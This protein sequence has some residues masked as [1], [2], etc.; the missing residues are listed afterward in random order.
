MAT[1]CGDAWAD[2]T[3][4]ELARSEASGIP[5]L[6]HSTAMPYS[7]R[8]TRRSTDKR[9]LYEFVDRS[10]KQPIEDEDD[11]SQYFEHFQTLSKPLIYF[12]FIFR[13]E[14][15]QLFWQGFYPNDRA[16]LLPYLVGRCSTQ[17]PGVE[18]NFQELFDRVHAIFSQWRHEDEEAKAEDMRQ[19]K[20]A[21]EEEDQE[22]EWLITGMWNWTSD[23]P[24]YA[25]LY[26]QCAHHFPNA[27]QGVPKPKPSPEPVQDAPL[28]RSV[29][30]YR[31]QPAPSSPA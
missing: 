23:D 16:R 19:W 8:S 4:S 11:V 5:P 17:Q 26:R 20:L 15:N 9:G 14:C 25:V 12:G 13:S 30:V 28:Q 31:A 1:V 10:S 27:L 3:W 7:H 2:V 18:F 6:H 21:Q 24:T 22:L 29:H